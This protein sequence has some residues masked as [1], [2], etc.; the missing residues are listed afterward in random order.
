MAG[1]DVNPIQTKP[2]L[3]K[4]KASIIKLVAFKNGKH[5]VVFGDLRWLV[6]REDKHPTM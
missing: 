6:S 5:S 4:I 3:F 1:R 2:R